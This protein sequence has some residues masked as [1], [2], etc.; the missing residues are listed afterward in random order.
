MTSIISVCFLWFLNFLLMQ[1]PYI[2]GDR[3]IRRAQPNAGFTLFESLS[4]KRPGFVDFD[5]LDSNAVTFS[6]EER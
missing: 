6:V 5:D 3:Y 4:L 2:Y 1:C